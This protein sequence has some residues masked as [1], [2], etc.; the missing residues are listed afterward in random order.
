MKNILSIIIVTTFFE[1]IIHT[2]AHDP[3]FSVVTTFGQQYKIPG[4]N[5]NAT[6]FFPSAHYNMHDQ[7]FATDD[8]RNQMATSSTN[9]SINHENNNHSN[10]SMPQPRSLQAIKRREE[11]LRFHQEARLKAEQKVLAGT[12]FQRELTPQLEQRMNDQIATIR[13]ISPTIEE[14]FM[15]E[16][17]RANLPVHDNYFYELYNGFTLMKEFMDFLTKELS[18]KTN[19]SPEDIYVLARTRAIEDLMS[20]HV[21]EQDIREIISKIPDFIREHRY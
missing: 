13:R 8:V 14:N 1:S 2:S 6:P 3:R 9:P 18:E 4:R 17:R 19:C 20:Q 7:N 15:L 10:I 11:F 16:F 21:T 12:D 5:L